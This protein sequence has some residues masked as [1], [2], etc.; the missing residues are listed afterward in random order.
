MHE[1]HRCSV[2]LVNFE[3]CEMVTQGMGQMGLSKKNGEGR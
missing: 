2:M 1:A 3:R